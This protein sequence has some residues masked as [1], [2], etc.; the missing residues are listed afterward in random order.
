[1]RHILLALVF[2]LAAAVSAPA[3]E[4]TFSQ[5][6]VD[7]PDGWTSD[8]RPG[9]QS[10]HPDEYMLLLGKRGEE[11]VEAHISIFIL[12]NKDGMDARTFASRMREMQDAP[13]ELQQEGTMWTFR[14]TP[15]SRAL[16]METL[17]RVSAD[18]AR[19]LIIMEQDPAGLG[20]ARVVD[21]LRGLTPASKALLGR[22][23]PPLPQPSGP[24]AM[25]V[26]LFFMPASGKAKGRA[27]RPPLHDARHG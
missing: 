25:R 13:T 20:T 22:S 7:L 24:S 23:P 2:L 4:K 21:S 1:M 12:P 9:F 26:A 6:A 14:G 15:R 16:A 17:T 27:R 11:A 10:G 3:A 18:D 19:I 8:E 5:F